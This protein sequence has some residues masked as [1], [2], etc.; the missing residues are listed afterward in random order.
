MNFNFKKTK[1]LQTS[2]TKKKKNRKYNVLQQNS[3]GGTKSLRNKFD[4]E[5]ES[6][7]YTPKHIY[8][9]NFSL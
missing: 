2:E 1:G 8:R 7:L 4:N 6:F 9:P 5:F 3:M